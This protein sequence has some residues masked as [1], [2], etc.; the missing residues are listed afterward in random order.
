[1]RRKEVSRRLK[2]VAEVRAALAAHRDRI[3]PLLDGRLPPLNGEGV[4]SYGGCFDH[5]DHELEQVEDQ[6]VVAEDEHTRK[7]VHISQER[8]RSAELTA[9]LSDKQIPARKTLVGLFG[10]DRDFELAAISG[11]TPQSP[12]ILA[13][14]VDQTIKLLRDPEGELPQMKIGGVMVDLDEM[15]DDLVS[16]L[17]TLQAA[18]VEYDRRRKEADATRVVTN[19]AIATYDK[20]FPWA[21]RTLESLFRLVG[22]LT[23]ADRIR[24]SVRRVTRRQGESEQD[25]PEEQATAGESSDES[26]SGETA[27]GD[28]STEENASPPS[29]TVEA[30][31]PTA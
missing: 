23:L 24:T 20:V 16:D 10:E 6:L 17:G 27:A 2:S 31:Q 28:D 3:I 9:D 30:A 4:F 5:L 14:Q 25:P 11:R 22:E 12:R 15:A 1:M 19:E 21:T 29:E 18:R 13:E 26:P 8:R 7:R